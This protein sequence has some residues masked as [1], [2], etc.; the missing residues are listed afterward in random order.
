MSEL[1][2]T[3]GE[4]VITKGD[5]KNTGVLEIRA[6][7]GAAG[8]LEVYFRHPI[9]AEV[10]AKM[11]VGNYM[12]DQ[13]DKVYKSILL[14]HPDP[15]AKA[16]GR[17][18]TRPA[19]YTSTKNIVG[20]TDFDFNQPPRG[21]LL[22]N[23]EALRQGFSLFVELKNPVPYDTLRKWGKMLMDGCSDIIAASRPFTMSWYA[24]EST[25]GKL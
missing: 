17:V 25:P 6:D 15:K 4:A 1:K 20:G 7:N 19:I 5:G 18:V 24:V 8:R 14:E 10:I 23:P 13:F 11:G 2:E 21:V 9:L 3:Q 16:A 22:S 12:G